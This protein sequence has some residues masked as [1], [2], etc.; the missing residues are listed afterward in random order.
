MPST[1][2]QVP[3]AGTREVINCPLCGGG[4]RLKYNE[5]GYAVGYEHML[6]IDIDEHLPEIDKETAEYLREQ[7]KGKKTVAIV[8]MSPTSCSLAPYN[9][10][11]V[12]I[13]GLNEEH[14]FDWFKNKDGWFQLHKPQSFRRHLAKRN[15]YGHYA[16]LKKKHSFPI[17]MQHKYP[18]VPASVEFPLHDIWEDCLSKVWRGKEKVRFCTSTAAF[19]VALAIHQKY[20]R[21][22]IYGV[23]MSGND[24]Y[25]PQRDGMHFWMGI[26]IGRGI[27]IYVPGNNVLMMGRLYGYED[28]DVHLPGE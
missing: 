21:I 19:M 17:Y 1:A 22:E 23:D 12:D 14:A 8:G 18:D 16:W 6:D 25:I 3:L 28:P 2:V 11:G 10:P 20:E 4:V 26:A 13:W 24:E 27:E 7:R 5:P 9:E 15:V